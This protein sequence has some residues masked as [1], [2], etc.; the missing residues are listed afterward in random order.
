MNISATE[1]LQL[2]K[3]RLDLVMSANGFIW[4]SLSAGNGSGGPFASGRYMKGDRS[5]ELHVRFSLGVVT[6]H[7][8][9]LSIGHEEYM[10]HSAPK[11]AAHYP[12][13][14]DDPLD[15][16]DN[17]AHDLSLYASDFLSGPGNEFKSAKVASEKRAKTSGFQRLSST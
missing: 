8:G 13:F 9:N 15:G 4:E 14:P 12:G 2:G 17:L 7:I 11:G 16:F 6:Y 3:K 1:M 5:L 10:R